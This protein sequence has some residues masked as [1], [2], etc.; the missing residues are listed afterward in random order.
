MPALLFLVVLVVVFSITTSGFFSGDNFVAIIEQAIIIAIV[1]LAVNQV[2][3]TAEID[4]SVGSVLAVC[5]FVF[6]NL[7]MS[8]GG[9]L[10]P[11][12]GSLAVGLAI[13]LVNGLLTAYGRVPSIIVTLGA[14]FVYRGLVLTYGGAQ[15]INVPAESRVL[16]LSEIAGIP[17]SI[18]AAGRAGCHRLLDQPKHGLGHQRLRRRR[19]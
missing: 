5:A 9:V 12:A 15:V 8:F 7:A 3:L 6:G 13:G 1:G 11:L 2:I 10:L 17:V 4:V 14:L 18:S 16:G 19:Q